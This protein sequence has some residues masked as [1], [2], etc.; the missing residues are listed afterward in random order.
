MHSTDI[1]QQ[2]GTPTIIY[3]LDYLEKLI[4][5]RLN[6]DFPSEDDS[7]LPPFPALNTWRKPWI[8]FA[9]KNKLEDK[10]DE[11]TLLLIA[12]APHMKPDLF[13]RAIDGKMNRPKDYPD[14]GGIRGKNC[15]FFLPTGETALFLIAGDDFDQR[16]QVQ[17]LFGSDHLFWEKKIMWLEDMQNGEPSMHGR[18]I[19]SPDY[20]DLLMNGTHKSPQFS[21]TFPAKKISTIK[22]PKTTEEFLSEC[23]P[24][25]PSPWDQLVINAEL[26]DQ[27]GEIQ[28]WLRFNEP[29]IKEFGKDKKFRQGFRSLFFGPPGTGKTFTAKLLGEEL[30]REVYKIDLSMIVSKYIGET[31]KNLELLFAK[32]EDKKWILF[33]DEADSLFGKRTSVRD[34]HDKY[35]NQEV[36]YLLQ[37]IEDY[38]GLIIL[39]TNMKNNIDDAFIRRFNSILKFPVPNADERKLIW[40]K[41]FPEQTV[42]YNDPDISDPQEV[43]IPEKAK[44]YELTGGNINNV[45]H[46]ACLKAFERRSDQLGHD[47]CADNKKLAV[48]LVDVEDGIRREF[49]KEGKPFQLN[50]DIN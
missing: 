30:N 24:P 2:T 29:F 27:I 3:E 18:L 10:K 40:E 48:Y 39:A 7:V 15:R 12:M 45:V 26:K 14:I 28:A 47:G 13:D 6:K 17:Q 50:K 16:L 22:I 21:I 11:L 25:P 9:K 19:I 20:V 41:S 32:A 37:R 36:S 42:F 43:N 5:Y 35:A 44:K 33:F 4:R 46:F 31:E 23:D 1:N 49:V 8:D 34:A 38:D